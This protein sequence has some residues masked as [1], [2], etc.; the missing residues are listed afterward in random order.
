MGEKTEQTRKHILTQARKV[1]AKK[2]FATVT[3]QDIVKACEI[4]RGGLYLYFGKTEEIFRAVLELD[5][6][7]TDDNEEKL[8]EDAGAVDLLA[9]FMK[10]QKREILAKNK[11]E[12]LDRAIYEYYFYMNG[13]QL[14][15]SKKDNVL[16]RDFDTGVLIL[17]NLIESGV[18]SG[19]LICDDPEGAAHSI[20]YTIEGLKISACTFGLPEADLDRELYSIMRGLV[21]EE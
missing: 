19:E 6:K 1:F 5:E 9:I 3:M 7:Q 10:E 12:T 20:M 16:K 21:E 11:K 13:E 4:S 8:P 15:L 17:E 14:K 2:G 18:A